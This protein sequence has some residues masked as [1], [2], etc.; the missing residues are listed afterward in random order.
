MDNLPAIQSITTSNEALRVLLSVAVGALDADS[1]TEIKM[2]VEEIRKGLQKRARAGRTEK[3]RY[4]ALAST[5][6]EEVEGWLAK[7]QMEE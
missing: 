3:T 5:T 2:L 1:L 6:L 7:A 4:L